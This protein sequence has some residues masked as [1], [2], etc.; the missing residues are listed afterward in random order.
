MILWKPEYSVGIQEL[1]K[2]H[3]YLIKLYND[4]STAVER[5]NVSDSYDQFLIRKLELF[6]L[7]YFTSEEHMM[8]IYGYPDLEDH[9]KEHEGFIS[10]LNGFKE[11]SLEYEIT[12][13]EEIRDFLKEWIVKHSLEKDEKYGQFVSDKMSQ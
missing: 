1:D 13:A 4:L 7:F 10:R 3:Q 5:G 9:R 6:A 11:I 8:E 12:L 2:Q